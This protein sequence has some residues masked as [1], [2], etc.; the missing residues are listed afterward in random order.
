MPYDEYELRILLTRAAA[1]ALMPGDAKHLQELL[2]KFFKKPD[3]YPALENVLNIFAGAEL[4]LHLTTS[5]NKPMAGAEVQFT[6]DGKTQV[7]TTDAAGL[8]KVPLGDIQTGNA[9]FT[10]TQPGYEKS[11]T[12]I[13]GGIERPDPLPWSPNRS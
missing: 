12:T 7:I 6:V 5:D 10:A 13:N 3:P 1:G 4:G 8:A 2:D 9:T 11:I